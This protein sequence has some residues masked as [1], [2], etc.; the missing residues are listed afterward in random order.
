MLTGGVLAD[1][2][3]DGGDCRGTAR[4]LGGDDKPM[5]D[6]TPR[7][8]T[9]RRVIAMTD[10]EPEAFA[11][12]GEW[13]VGTGDVA[14]L[15]ERFPDAE[16]TDF[17]DGVVIPGLNDAHQHP[18]MVAEDLL[19]AD[20]SPD[21]V[22][23]RGEILAVMRERAARVPPGDWVRGSRYDHTKSSGGAVLS[24]A[25]LDEISTEQPVL[26]VHVAGHWGVVNSR[27]LAVA[28]LGDGSEDPPGGELGRDGAGRLTGVLYEQ[29]LFDLAYPAVSRGE[30]VIPPS[31]IDGKLRALAEY[32]RMLHAAGITS[33]GDALV[34]PDGLELLQAARRR[35]ELSLRVNMLVAYPHFD[36]MRRLGLSTGLGDTRLRVGGIKAFVDGAVGGGTC[37]LEEPYTGGGGHGIQTVTSKEL[38]DLVRQVHDSGSRVGVHA[39]GDR[40]IKLLLAALEEADA[41]YPRPD[42]RHRIEHCS[43]VDDEIIARMRRLGAVAVP[44]GSYVAFHGGTLVDYYGMQRLE[45]MFAVRSLLD[46]GV[47]VAGSSDYPCGPYEPLLA[48]QSCVTREAADGTVLGGS[49]RISRRE[50]L[51]LYTTGSA[52]AAGEE[53]VKGR[54]TAGHLADFVVL[55][56]DPLTV[57]PRRLSG[58]AVRQTWVGADRVWPA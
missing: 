27:G 17:G 7:I 28:G 33:V 29:A 11:C 2:G 35:G 41:A 18:T 10:A 43:V 26:V 50:A 23:T 12:L 58:I 31:G 38:T 42:A 19:H 25:D 51:A 6:S 44:F 53:D 45:R 16:V 13:V 8:F 14:R 34:G 15:R 1:H 47:G 56:E 21:N 5:T 22:G 49:Q 55:D 39:N 37:L 54:L 40:A 52:Y 24:R 4:A 9:A 3:T 30:P 36:H 46:A 20:L 32:S 57:D 48:L